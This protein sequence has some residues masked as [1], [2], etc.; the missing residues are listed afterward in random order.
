MQALSSYR[1]DR[2]YYLFDRARW[3]DAELSSEQQYPYWVVH[4]KIKLSSQDHAAV[5]RGR[6]TSGTPALPVACQ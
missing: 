4:V 6:G 1:P 2:R 3:H 5:Y